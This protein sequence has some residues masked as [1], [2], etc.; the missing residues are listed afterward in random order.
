MDVKISNKVGRTFESTQKEAIKLEELFNQHRIFGDERDLELIS[1][2]CQ[3]TEVLCVI[4]KKSPDSCPKEA[5]NQDNMIVMCSGCV[6][7]AINKFK[8][9]QQA[10]NR[11][12]IKN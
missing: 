5:Y 8:E 7:K 1:P 10:I 3:V 4:D 11:K 9:L 2:C 12:R 6:E